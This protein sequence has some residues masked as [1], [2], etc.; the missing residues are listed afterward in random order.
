MADERT[1]MSGTQITVALIGASAVIASALIAN[2]DKLFKAPAPAPTAPLASPSLSPAAPASS[3]P[4]AAI[5][6]PRPAAP[7]P[8]MAGAWRGDDGSVWTFVQQGDR[9]SAEESDGD[10][11]V[12]L[13]GQLNGQAV[14]IWVDYYQAASGGLGLRIMNCE[15]GLSGD[16]RQLQLNCLN[17][18]T[19]VTS[20]ANWSRV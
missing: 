20:R 12:R 10:E 7:A 16:G 9:F 19:N 3:T 11:R 15:G 1:G 2:S 17:P 5:E 13:E 18:Q 6:T 8:T 14:R 4:A